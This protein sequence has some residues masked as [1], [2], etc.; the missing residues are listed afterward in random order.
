MAQK[1]D[2]FEEYLINEFYDDYREGTITRRTFI[3]RVAFITGSMTATIAAMAVAGCRP[4]E[5]PLPD[6]P[7]P[8]PKAASGQ[9]IPVPDAQSPFSVPEGDPDVDAVDVTFLSQGDEIAAYL[10]RPT[11]EGIYPAI[12]VLPRKPRSEPAYP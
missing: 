9:L 8:V 2:N 3:R 6:E 1:T 12:L 10:A 11:A 4:I 5:L 7:M